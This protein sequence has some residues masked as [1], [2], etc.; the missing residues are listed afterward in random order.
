MIIDATNTIMGRV[1]A[2][3]AKKALEGE[4]VDIINSEKAIISGKRS[5]VVARFRQ[6]R[7]RGGPYH[8]PY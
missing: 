7:N 8:G 6:Q 3:A 2:T 4:K 1:A 5:T